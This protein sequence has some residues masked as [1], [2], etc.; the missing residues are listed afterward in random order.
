MGQYLPVLALTI[1]GILFGAL[2][3]VE[4]HRPGLR[5][6]GLRGGVDRQLCFFP[7]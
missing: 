7:E 5:L 3:F 2:S 6:G 1:L 4:R